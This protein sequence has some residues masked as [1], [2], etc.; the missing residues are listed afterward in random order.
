M[1]EIRIYLFIG[2]RLIPLKYGTSCSGF[3][4]QNDGRGNFTDITKD[5]A[6]DLKGIGMIT[7]AKF[8]DLDLDGDEDL[9]IVG[10]YMGIEILTNESGKFIKRKDNLLANL[11]GWWNT[12]EAGDLDGDGDVDFI[13]GNHGL[14]SRFKASSEK[15]ITLYSKDFDSNGFIDPILTFRR[16]DG[17]DYPYALRHN[18]I[19]QIKSVSKKFPDYQSFKSA[20]IVDIFTALELEGAFKLEANTLNSVVLINNGDYSF[21][22]KELPKEAQFSTVYSIAIDDFDADGD[23]DIALGGNLYNVK[24][25]VGRYDASYGVFLENQGDMIFSYSNDGNGFKVK[26][27]IRDMVVDK[28]KLIVTKNRDSVAIFKFEK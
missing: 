14:N 18:L 11:K 28:E 2:E 24:P 10:E 27:E 4:L 22:V 6:N 23:Q 13:V 7:D 1:M 5:A 8:K 26:G 17:L 20:S 3:L 9:I 15:P 21:K 25:E 16:D 19:D 12:I